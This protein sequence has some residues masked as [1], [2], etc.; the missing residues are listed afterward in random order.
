MHTRSVR[1]TE[2]ATGKD[3]SDSVGGTFPYESAMNQCLHREL[4]GRVL[5]T[6]PY[7][8]QEVKLWSWPAAVFKG[9]LI[10]YGTGVCPEVIVKSQH[11]VTVIT[12]YLPQMSLEFFNIF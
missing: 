7:F 4:E 12:T 8:R 11:Q 2:S 5:L 9:S 10:Y 6:V 3:V 1:D